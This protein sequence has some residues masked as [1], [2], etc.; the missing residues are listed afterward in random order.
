MESIRTLGRRL[1]HLAAVVAL[2]ASAPSAWAEL[3]AEQLA[4]TLKSYRTYQASFIQ[5]LVNENGGQVQETRGELKAKRPGLF[6]WSTHSPMS[7]FIVSDGE[8]VT[9]YDPDLEQVTIHKLDQR[10]SSTPALLLSGEVDN[11]AETYDISHRA[12]GNETEEFTLTPRNPDSLFVSLKLSFVDGELQEMRM[13]DS[14]AQLSILSFDSIRLNQDL[15]DSAFE[16]D[17]PES[18]DVIQDAP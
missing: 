1:I 12:L 3:A 16:L 8:E 7:Q 10:A 13:R 4:D 17:Y 5:I 2:M 18:V 15:A 9:L 14:L 6:Y 11:L